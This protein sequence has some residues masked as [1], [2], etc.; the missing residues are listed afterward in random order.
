L[1]HLLDPRPGLR[2]LARVLEPG[3]KLL[4]LTTEETF[5]GAVCSR[6]WHCR[7]YNRAALRQACEECGLAWSRE[8][9]FSRLHAYFHLGGITVELMRRS[10]AP[11][12]GSL[13]R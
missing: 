4:V 13:A 2:E 11:Q 6:L 8:L 10:A 9:W 5:N 3:G 7:T 12:T 1:E